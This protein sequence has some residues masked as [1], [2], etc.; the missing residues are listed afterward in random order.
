MSTIFNKKQI[1][2]YLLLKK[3]IFS[4]KKRKLYKTII[5]VLKYLKGYYEM[6][7]SCFVL[8]KRADPESTGGSHWGT[9]PTLS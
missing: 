2:E 1:I 7:E 3:E 4:L 8:F 9:F 5:P 6:K